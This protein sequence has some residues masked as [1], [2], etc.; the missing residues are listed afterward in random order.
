MRGVASELP[1]VV[2]GVMTGPGSRKRGARTLFCTASGRCSRAGVLPAL[3]CVCLSAAANA[4]TGQDAAAPV[5]AAL[6]SHDFAQALT[7]SRSAL[8]ANPGDFRIWTLRGMATAGTND[9]PGAL[10]AYEHALELQPTY[11]P[12][13]EG[14]AQTEFQMGRDARPVLS[15]ILAQRPDDPLAHMLFGIMDA[16]SDDCKGAVEHFSHA[17]AVI[18]HSPEALTDD[19][20]C[21]AETNQ[22]AEAVS[23]FG[24]AL[25]L[26]PGSAPAR[27]NVA[28]AEFSAHDADGALVTLEPLTT[29]TPAHPDALV[30]A[31]QIEESKGDT[32][33][34]VTLLRNALLADPKRMDAYMQFATLSF[35]HA[36]PQVGIDIVNAGIGQMPNEPRL[37]LVRG[38]LLAQVG[39]FTRAADDFD[40][41]NRLDPRL[42]FLGEAQGLVQSQ[43]HNSAAALAKFRAAVKVHPG[44]AYGW[45]L[46][47]EALSG[48]GNPEGSPQ[49]AEEMQAAKTAVKLDPK[50]VEARD[51]LSATYYAEGHM[52]ESIEQSR[53]ALAVNPKD[54]AAVYH[55]MLALRQTGHDDEAR[56]LVQQ[57]L[58]LRTNSKVNQPPTRYHQLSEREE[59]G[60]AMNPPNST[61]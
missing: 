52:Q 23:A 57:L 58:Q 43:E 39:E 56:A 21:L 7:L 37:Y 25:A 55:L 46:L 19:G 14:D 15:R 28:L 12:A 9:L 3:L 1:D 34:A 45:Y 33:Q 27:Y 41:A 60:L 17:A 59:P 18:E 32:E 40:K 50:L 54:E 35:D 42:Q 5:I 4:Q 10:S 61:Q 53:A 48:E 44:E 30:L 13:L 8:A 2:G 31:A 36:S 24:A 51:L 47:A 49:Y 22:Y 11:L 29:A 16:R 6:R 38:I 20:A 26:D